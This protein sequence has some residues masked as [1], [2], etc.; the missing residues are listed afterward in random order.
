MQRMLRVEDVTYFV[1]ELR[2]HLHDHLRFADFRETHISV[3]V[4]GPIRSFETRTVPANQLQTNVLLT[5]ELACTF[6]EDE[7]HLLRRIT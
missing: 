6:L 1:P 5:G 4:K 2:V 7:P 3:K